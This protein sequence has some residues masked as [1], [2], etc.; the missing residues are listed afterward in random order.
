M[1]R[2]IAVKTAYSVRQT[3]A[4]RRAALQ[5]AAQLPEDIEEARAVLER[6]RDLLEGFLI[7]PREVV[8]PLRLAKPPPLAPNAPRSHALRFMLAG[9]VAAT[10]LALA[11]GLSIGREPRVCW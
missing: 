11:L 5:I 9:M 3:D 1:G 2:E 8:R 6:T 7:P 4:C 10:L